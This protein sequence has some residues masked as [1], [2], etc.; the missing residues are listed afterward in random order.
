MFSDSFYTKD[1]V[2]QCALKLLFVRLN[3]DQVHLEH[4]GEVL[5]WLGPLDDS[6]VDRFSE[7]IEKDWFHGI[8]SKGQAEEV[9]P[10]DKSGVY[11]VRF[12]NNNPNHFCYFKSR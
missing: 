2:L 6:F 7:M 12:S 4:F 9:L 11:L 10:K 1:D 3:D 8:M 5:G